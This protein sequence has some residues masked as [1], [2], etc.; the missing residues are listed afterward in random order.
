MI[1]SGMD[2]V[3][4][5]S[6]AVHIAEK[7]EV[8]VMNNIMSMLSAVVLTGDDGFAEKWI[9]IMVVVGVVLVALA[10]VSVVMS[11]KKKNAEAEE[12]KEQNKTD[13]KK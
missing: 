10:A 1:Y 5:I 2:S 6:T 8:K 11:K 7:W 4:K 9:W 3:C 13:D 12:G